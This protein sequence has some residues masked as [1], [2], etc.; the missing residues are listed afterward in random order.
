MTPQQIKE[1]IEK[2]V[3]HSTA[4]VR[5]PQNDGQHFEAFVVSS[6]F[7]TMMLIKQHQMV[8]KVLKNAFGG[9]L[10]ALAL[11]TFT[12]ETWNKGASHG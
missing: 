2:A 1:V 9:A 3:P 4:Y 5:D 6:L 7:G 12:P 10:H 11:K 8:M